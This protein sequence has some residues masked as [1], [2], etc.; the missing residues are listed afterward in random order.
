[1]SCLSRPYHRLSHTSH[2]QTDRQ[3]D[4]KQPGIFLASSFRLNSSAVLVLSPIPVPCS[5]AVSKVCRDLLCTQTSYK[6]FVVFILKRLA[7]YQ[8]QLRNYANLLIKWLIGTRLGL[9]S[10]ATPTH[11]GPYRPPTRIRC[12]HRRTLLNL[13]LDRF[14]SFRQLRFCGIALI[15]CMYHLCLVSSFLLTSYFH[16][17]AERLN[18]FVLNRSLQ[19]IVKCSG[20]SFDGFAAHSPSSSRVSSSFYEY[21]GLSD[22]SSEYRS[23][24][25]SS[26]PQLIC[27]KTEKP[28]PPQAWAPQSYSP[29]EVSS[30]DMTCGSLALYLHRSVPGPVSI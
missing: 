14:P 13:F 11:S 19:A 27:M 29:Y 10:P 25:I 17:F 2:I 24:Q 4:N 5:K 23:S 9:P 30:I 12:N 15:T 20:M 3:T 26:S 6:V 21:S 16:Y 28:S 8:R 1:M 18:C 22:A 7:D